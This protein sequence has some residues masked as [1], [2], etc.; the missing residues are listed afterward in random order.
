MCSWACSAWARSAPISR[1]ARYGRW[2][3]SRPSVPPPRPIIETL[4]AA[5]LETLAEPALREQL[6]RAG[7]DIMTTT[8]EQTMEMLRAENQR[9]API[10]PGLNLRLD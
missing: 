8:P 5:P 7:F 4:H 2:P 1:R 3:C 9:W 10:L 6:T